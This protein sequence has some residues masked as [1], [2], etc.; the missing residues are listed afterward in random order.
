[1]DYSGKPGN[2]AGRPFGTPGTVLV[3]MLI[4]EGEV[5]S[6]EVVYASDTS[7][8][9]GI[10]KACDASMKLWQFITKDT[11]VMIPFYFDNGE[12]VSQ[13]INK[14]EYKPVV[15]ITPSKNEDFVIME[16]LS[17]VV[18]VSVDVLP[19]EPPKRQGR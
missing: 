3:S 8:V 4:K 16:P 13:K 17:L 11:R 6:W 5:K 2:I 15:K 7:L 10:K 9:A 12:D 14:G 1:M 18:D 19:K